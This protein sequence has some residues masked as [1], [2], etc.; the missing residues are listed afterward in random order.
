MSQ[1]GVLRRLDQRCITWGEERFGTG[2]MAG[3]KGAAAGAGAVLLVLVPVSLSTGRLGLLWVLVPQAFGI[4]LGL[5][6]A[7]VIGLGR[8]LKNVSAEVSEL[9]AELARRTNA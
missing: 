7:Y 8:A 3:A 4:G 2:P 6:V 9:R 5:L 1:A